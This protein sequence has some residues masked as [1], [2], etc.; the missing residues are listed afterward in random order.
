MTTNFE[1]EMCLSDT[2]VK[3]IRETGSV[4]LTVKWTDE[5]RH[6]KDFYHCLFCNTSFCRSGMY[7]YVSGVLQTR[8]L[9]M[10]LLTPS[11]QIQEGNK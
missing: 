11:C 7:Y 1:I 5:T 9:L 4:R 8:E 6:Q 10:M 3:N 2:D